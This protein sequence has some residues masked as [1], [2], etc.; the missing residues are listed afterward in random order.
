MIEPYEP[1]I[2]IEHLREALEQS[3]QKIK[4]LSDEL[5]N[6]QCQNEELRTQ[7]QIMK[8]QLMTTELPI[9]SPMIETAAVNAIADHK[10][11]D[12][13]VITLSLTEYHALLLQISKASEPLL[14]TTTPMTHA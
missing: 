7:L 8:Q 13:E 1:L 6:A 9:A 3:E 5:C 14:K 12:G 2:S 10:Q 11:S 4:L